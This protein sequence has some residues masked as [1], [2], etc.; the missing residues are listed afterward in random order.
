[1]KLQDYFKNG[2]N[3]AKALFVGGTV[4]AVL[5]WGKVKG[6]FGRVTDF[7]KTRKERTR[8]ILGLAWYQPFPNNLKVQKE[9]LEKIIETNSYEFPEGY[10]DE[11]RFNVDDDSKISSNK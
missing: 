8:M 6:L 2:L 9:E 5:L 7:A 1:M 4:L 11:Q 3:I 10:D